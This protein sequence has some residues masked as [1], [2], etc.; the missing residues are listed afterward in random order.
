[1][2]RGKAIDYD[3]ILIATGGEARTPPI[4]GL[5]AKYVYT[6]RNHQDQ[7]NIKE[8][9]PEVKQSIVIIGSSFIGSEAAASIK[10]KQKDIEVHMIGMEEYPLELA[11]G[12]EIGKMMAQ[13]HRENGVKL[14]MKAGVKEVTKNQYGNVSG[15]IL[16]DGTKIDANMVIVG[17]GIA[18]STKFLQRTETGI[19]TD[20]MGAI[21]CDP[22]LQSSIPDIYAAGDVCSF[23]YWQT[24]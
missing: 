8:R 24:G 9:I 11:L 23:P 2:Q 14:H 20:K 4:P 6:L 12:K 10:M 19:K 15:V 21:V 17:T 18:P 22:F 5:D 7:E 1:M 16:A 13:Q 3:K